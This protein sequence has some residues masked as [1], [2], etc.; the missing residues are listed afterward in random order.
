MKLLVDVGPRGVATLTLNRADKSNACDGEMLGLL[1][2]ALDRAARDDAIRVVALRG[3]GRHFCSGADLAAGRQAPEPEAPGAP[4][5]VRLPDLCRQLQR[6][7]KPTIAVAHGGCIGAG[8]ALVACCDVVLATPEAFFAIPE[9]RIGF[10]P[11]PLTLFFHAA[12]GA[13]GLRRYLLSGERF[14]VEEALRLGLVHAIHD[15]ERIEAALAA[16]TDEFLHAAPGA[17]AAAKANLG[18]LASDA[19]SEETAARLEAEFERHKQGPEAVEGL[20]SFREKRKP[21]WYPS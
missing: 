9:V 12:I 8:L 20:A 18:A 3:A 5:P 17:L 6:L 1:A 13:R 21:R 19:G 16:M 10:A 11:G 7:P 2:A 4:P 15:R 14:G